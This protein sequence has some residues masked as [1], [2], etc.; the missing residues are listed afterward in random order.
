M[1][2]DYHRV[3]WMKPTEEK[4]TNQSISDWINLQSEP[5]TPTWIYGSKRL[6]FQMVYGC[7]NLLSIS[8]KLDEQRVAVLWKMMCTSSC[9]CL[10]MRKAELLTRASWL[11]HESTKCRLQYAAQLLFCYFFFF[12]FFFIIFCTRSSSWFHN[13]WICSRYKS[14]SE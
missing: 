6:L 4:L 11:S 7:G 5:E 14:S 10:H 1:L 8:L 2:I 9:C 12:F 3:E 13:W